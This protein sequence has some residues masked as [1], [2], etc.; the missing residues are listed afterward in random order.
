MGS[1]LSE[2]FWYNCTPVERFGGC[3]LLPDRYESVRNGLVI[4]RSWNSLSSTAATSAVEIHPWPKL[5]AQLRTWSDLDVQIRII[6][7]PS[8]NLESRC[9]SY[10]LRSQAVSE[11]SCVWL[12]EN[13]SF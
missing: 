2:F 3:R 1:C 12:P 13:V 4:I 10:G 6:C 5:N 11:C 8:P 7:D 9:W